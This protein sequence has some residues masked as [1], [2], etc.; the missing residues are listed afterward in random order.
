MSFTTSIPPSVIGVPHRHVG[1]DVEHEPPRTIPIP[2][3]PARFDSV[4]RAVTIGSG[5][6]MTIGLVAAQILGT[7]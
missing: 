3:R 7:G 2:R 5:A 1:P 6:L 4:V